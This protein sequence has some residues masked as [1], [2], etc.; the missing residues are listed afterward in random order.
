MSQKEPGLMSAIGQAQR[1]LDPPSLTVGDLLERFGPIPLWR[2][3]FDVWPGTATEH[4][5]IAISDREGRACELV[6][7]VLVEKAT[8][9]RESV[10]AVLLIKFLG[11]FLD[12]NP[13]GILTGEQGAIRLAPGLIRIPDVGFFSWRQFPS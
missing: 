9:F 5:V 2:I 4:D 3:R 6:H 11:N 13:L 12:N 10:L 8:V 7:G 1:P